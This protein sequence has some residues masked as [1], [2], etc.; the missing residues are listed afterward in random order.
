MDNIPYFSVIVPA[1]QAEKTIK[2]CIDSVIKQSYQDFELIIINDGSTD[3]TYNICKGYERDDRVCIISQ[4]NKGISATRQ[5]GLS[6]SVGRYIQFIDSDDWVDASYF[7]VMHKL[8]QAYDYDVVILDYYA[9]EIKNTKYKS[10][11]IKSLDRNDLVKGLATNIPG[12][13]WNKVIKRD[14]F[15]KYN[16]GFNSG[17]SYCEDWVVSY[18]LF[19]A[20]SKIFY[21][22]KAFY[23][24]DLY[25]NVYSLARII[26]EKT[27]ENRRAYIEYIEKIGVR[28]LY[29]KVF[30][31]Q[32]AD[33]AYVIVRSNTY[34][35]S[36]YKKDFSF[37]RLAE[38]YL[39]FYRKVV[40][41]AA[42]KLNLK[43]AYYLDYAIR[44][45]TRKHKN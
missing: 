2:R 14:L 27:L 10:L 24:Y 11:G 15:Y 1:F 31:T 20:P 44:K 39:P 23:H 40:L 33:Y 35:N 30:Q 19:N 42:G 8:L 6:L 28:E 38:T 9:E 21:Y 45:L 32:Y 22:E 4:E 18:K 37:L 3:Q 13:L 36:Q 17:L 41:Y 12:V 5:L 16:I 29:P 26:N 25:S 7:E 34:S 43:L